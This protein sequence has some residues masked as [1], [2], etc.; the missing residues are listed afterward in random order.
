MGLYDSVRSSYNLGEE[1]TNVSL[2]TKDIQ[3]FIGGTLDFYWIDTSGKL[4]SIDFSNA[5]DPVE[6][7]KPFP[8]FEWISNGNRGKVSPVYIT[9]YVE[10]YGNPYKRCKI[11]FKRGI[12]QDFEV[13]DLSNEFF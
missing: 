7:N 5:I 10:V 3:D 8:A 2:Q 11:H 12:V 6:T 13:I 4:F 9:K 1:F